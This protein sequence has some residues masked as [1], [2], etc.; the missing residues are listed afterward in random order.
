MNA[1]TSTSSCF[2]DVPYPRWLVRCSIRHVA[3]YSH[4]LSADEATDD[5]FMQVKG[6]RRNAMADLRVANWD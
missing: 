3:P 1:F 6:E 5:V 4:F 2:S